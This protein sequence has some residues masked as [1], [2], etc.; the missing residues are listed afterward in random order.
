MAITIFVI[1]RF[2]IKAWHLPENEAYTEIGQW[3]P[4]VVATVVFAATLMARINGWDFDTRDAGS[5]N[6]GFGWL[7]EETLSDAEMEL[8]QAPFIPRQV[9]AGADGAIDLEPWQDRRRSLRRGSQAV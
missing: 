4:Y 3:G 8:E 1:A 9:I 7:L 6:R 2:E 5:E